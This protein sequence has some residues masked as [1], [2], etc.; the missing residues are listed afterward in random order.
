[1]GTDVQS[2]SP[3]N[4]T[5]LANL[6]ADSADQIDAAVAQAHSAFLTW[7]SV[8]APRRGELIRL[9]GEELRQNK[10]ELGHLVTLEAGKIVQ[11]GLGEVQE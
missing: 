7:R 8:P 3:I 4:G 1:A 6:R 9:L 10:A 2:I 5:L 11:E